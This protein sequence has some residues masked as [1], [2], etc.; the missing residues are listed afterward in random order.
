MQRTITFL[1]LLCLPGCARQAVDT[2]TN[3]SNL[4]SFSGSDTQPNASANTNTTFSD[5][6]LVDSPDTSQAWRSEIALGPDS[7]DSVQSYIGQ[8]GTQEH[9]RISRSTPEVSGNP[10]AQ[11]LLIAPYD[12]GM[13]FE[14]PS[15]LEMWNR[16]F[17]VH[18]NHLGCD[19]TIA[20][21]LNDTSCF[22]AAHFWVGDVDD[23]GG[24]MLTAYD[25]INSQGLLDRSQS[26]VMLASD[27]FQHTSH[28][29]M[30]F[31]L[32]DSSDNF[33]FQFGPEGTADSPQA[34][35]SYTM[36]RI[37]S[38]GKGFFDGGTQTGGADFAESFAVRGDKRNYEP[39]DV[40]AI[41][42][43]SDRRLVLSHSPYSTLVAGVYSTKP[44]VLGSE[45]TSEDPLLQD[46]IPM[47]VVGIV[48]CKVSTE[49]GPIARGDLLVSASTPGYAM[50]G[51]DRSRLT[52][53]V[54]GKALQPFNGEKGTI[55]V[56]VG[57]R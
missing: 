49:N 22:A 4:A 26:F 43:S 17:S 39:G 13:A 45:H 42:P 28:G 11:H 53:A 29:D 57:L 14:Y 48:P 46:E 27:T 20:D 40:L 5:V 47:A 54:V 24:W 31:V 1:C 18:Q 38:T 36:A 52:G 34:Y 44:G 21:Y 19:P 37:D 35:T 56:L 41:D 10:N 55:E 7:A 3:G 51:S 2:V 9:L 15:T 32:R 50:R 25:T 12:Y 33:R 30:L 6:V 23:T 16:N 8:A